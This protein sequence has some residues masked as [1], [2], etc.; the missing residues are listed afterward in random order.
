MDSTSTQDNVKE[1]L[2]LIESIK[3]PHP[4]GALLHSFILNAVNPLLAAQYV[5]DACQHPHEDAIDRQT[6]A[7]HLV[8]RWTKIVESSTRPQYRYF[9]NLKLIK[10]IV[11][12]YGC[13]PPMPDAATR[14]AIIRRDGGKCC[15]TGKAGSL[16]DPLVVIPILRVPSRWIREEVCLV[17][18]LRCMIRQEAYYFLK[19]ELTGMLN[20]F[21]TA[22]YSHQWLNYIRQP[23]RMD[24]ARN[25]WLVRKSAARAFDLGLVKLVSLQQSNVEVSFSPYLT[26]ALHF[27]IF[28]VAE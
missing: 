4:Y 23:E 21:F 18:P 1:A 28:F 22:R 7:L 9:V 10:I 15:I 20:A 12:K 27:F 25:H 17:V 19:L 26:L 2:L 5:L 24:P 8:I 11:S 14:A 6:E 16:W 3:L 13:P